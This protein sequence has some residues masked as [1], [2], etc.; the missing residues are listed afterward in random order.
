M[1]LAAA[2][3]G[4]LYISR[5]SGTTWVPVTEAN[6]NSTAWQC[7]A[8]SADGAR[9]LAGGS[10]G[11]LIA[12]VFGTLS[13]G[14]FPT[15]FPPSPQL[16]TRSANS[17]L[18]LSWLVPSSSFLLQQSSDLASLDSVEVTNPPT[19]N[20]TNLHNEVVLPLSPAGRGFYRLKQ[21]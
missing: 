9:I 19:L 15:S 6:S 14:G 1:K 2:I 8:S 18:M 10:P 11:R 4:T 3:G 20:F 16:S 17:N 21:K 5:D 13:Y 7:V 12:A